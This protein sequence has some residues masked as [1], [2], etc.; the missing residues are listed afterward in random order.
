MTWP[1]VPLA[2]ETN[3]LEPTASLK[4]GYEFGFPVMLVGVGEAIEDLQPF[5]PR[6]YV[7]ALVA[8]RDGRGPLIAW[9]DEDDVAVDRVARLNRDLDRI[10]ARWCVV[11][12]RVVPGVLE[13]RTQISAPTLEGL[14]VVIVHAVLLI[15]PRRPYSH[16]GA[17]A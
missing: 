3:P 15:S 12:L 16:A 8:G 17:P 5:D 4:I 13:S 2:F 6:D 7:L 9:G 11:L 1:F 14:V 10:Q